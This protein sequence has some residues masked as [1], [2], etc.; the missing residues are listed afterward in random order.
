MH[1]GSVD[2]LVTDAA[3]KPLKGALIDA[4]L[5]ALLRDLSIEKLRDSPA[6]ALSGGERRRV[7]IARALA[8]QPRFI[9]LDEPFA[10]IDPIAVTVSYAAARD[11]VNHLRY[12]DDGS[13]LRQ[14][15]T[16]LRRGTAFEAAFV[17]AFGRSLGE[18]DGEW[19]SGLSGRFVWFPVISSGGLPFAAL[20]PLIVVAAVRRR[21]VLRE[22]WDR[23]AR[24]DE[25]LHAEVAA[26]LR[27]PGLMLTQA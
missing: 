2:V 3:G 5:D 24:E 27:R 23:L 18:L 20:S 26:V 22:G 9:L 21:R 11:F 1:A 4:R 12:R 13:D 6:P 7:E 16:E 15:M 8:T 14:L 19:R 25:A 17:K 10:G